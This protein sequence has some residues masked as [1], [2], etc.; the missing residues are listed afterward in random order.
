MYMYIVMYLVHTQVY[1]TYIL[2]THMLY[3]FKALEFQL[4][5]KHPEVLMVEG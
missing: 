4:T 1:N 2:T 5:V 3:S